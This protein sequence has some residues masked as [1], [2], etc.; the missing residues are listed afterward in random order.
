MR[1]WP[2]AILM[3]GQ[4]HHPGARTKGIADLSFADRW[5]LHQA[6]VAGEITIVKIT[7]RDERHK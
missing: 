7:G 2:D 5:R 4:L 1:G 3:P 6:L